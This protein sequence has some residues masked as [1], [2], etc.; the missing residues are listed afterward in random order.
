MAD[1]VLVYGTE[2]W[3]S[4]PAPA[5]R[6]DYILDPFGPP[7]GCTR[8]SNETGK[9]RTPLNS[10]P[11]AVTKVNPP[12]TRKPQIVV[13]IGTE[14]TGTTTLQSAL[15]SADSRLRANGIAYLPT[16]GRADS[17]ALAAA[18]L[19]KPGYDEY[20]RKESIDTAEKLSAFRD[21]V[22]ADVR[23]RIAELPDNCHSVVISSEHFH[24]RLRTRESVQYLQTCLAPA[25]ERIR[26][27][28]YLRRQVDVA[29]SFYSTLLKTGGT[30]TLEQAVR[31]VCRPNNHYYN[32]QAMLELWADVFGPDALEV[33]RFGPEHLQGGSIVS[34]FLYHLALPADAIPLPGSTRNRSINRA[35]QALI[36]A[37]NKQFTGI[38]SAPAR[39]AGN[40]TRKA[41]GRIFTGDGERL[42]PDA[43]AEIQSRFD[44][45]NEAIRDRWFLG[46]RMLFPPPA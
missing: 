5:H 1:S 27:V 31:R 21:R 32:Y 11:A 20:L 12:M 8:G 30:E 41:I 16:P 7:L 10:R 4:T 9:R 44:E 6:T 17:R 15:N 45:I 28:C 2:Y 26:I 33:R 37:L 24:S 23:T 43:E 14:K 40:A 35:G 29:T 34:D 3:K 36:R 19:T 46:E 22:F 18:C 13:H 42:P 25:T 38:E 39:S